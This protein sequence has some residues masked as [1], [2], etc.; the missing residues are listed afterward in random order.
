MGI[1]KADPSKVRIIIANENVFAL[2][3]I[4]EMTVQVLQNK[5]LLKWVTKYKRDSS[6]RM[7]FG[8]WTR[9]K[10]KRK[11]FLR[12]GDVTKIQF[13]V[14]LNSHYEARALI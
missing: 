11:H 4:A 7:T 10:V 8:V 14:F 1:S 9:K 6:C 12:L 2:F 3:Y 13:K 5:L